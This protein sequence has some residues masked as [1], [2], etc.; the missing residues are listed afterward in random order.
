VPK[1]R[2]SRSRPRTRGTAPRLMRDA[3]IDPIKQMNE[4]HAVVSEGGKTVVITEDYDP[5]LGRRVLSRSSFPDIRNFYLNARIP[6][7]KNADGS[8]QF[9]SLGDHWLKHPERRQYKGIVFSP[10]KDAHGYFNLWRGFSVEPR[11]GDW[12]LMRHHLRDC[13]CG[14][15]D[16]HFRYLMAW[17][18]AAIQRPDEPAEVAVA[19]RGRRGTGKSVVGR[20]FGELFGQHFI[21]VANSRHLVGN[22][23]AHLQDA[24][25]VF[26]DE[27]FE[28]GDQRAEAVLKMLITEPVIPIERKHRDV[29]SA[30]NMT[31]LLIA[32]NDAWVVP[33]GL[34]ERRFFVLDVSSEHAQDH[35]YFGRLVEQMT[36]GGRAAMLYDLL[37]FDLS[38]VNLRQPPR[39]EALLEQK[40][41]SMPPCVRWW[42]EKLL[43]GRLLSSHSGWEQEILRDDLQDDYATFRATGHRGRALATELG[44]QLKKV[45]P[46]GFPR[47]IQRSAPSLN[48]DGKTHRPRYWEFPSLHECRR[49]FDG[50]THA[51]HPWPTDN[52]EIVP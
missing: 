39:T 13:I 6:I 40:L 43:D 15:N 36:N 47:T 23:N 27:A 21:H 35:H 37:E 3:A 46:S 20:Q 28:A 26:S 51:C 11:Q 41:L 5:V 16:E 31:H 22:F 18:A 4:R 12:S 38:T 45:L 17:K 30:K 29:I 52:V 9:E 1:R 2:T 49:H 48:A 24:I 14:G 19:F 8:C 10:G 7:A 44:V 33:A 50:I 42:Y 32:S 34:D 25:F